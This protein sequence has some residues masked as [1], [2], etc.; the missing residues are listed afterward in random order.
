MQSPYELY[1]GKLLLPKAVSELLE[2]EGGDEL[3]SLSLNA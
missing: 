1:R 3:F 2:L